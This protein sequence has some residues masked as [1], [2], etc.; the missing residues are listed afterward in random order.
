LGEGLGRGRGVTPVVQRITALISPLSG[1]YESAGRP[2]PRVASR[3]SAALPQPYRR[4]LVHDQ[5]MTSTL[6]AYFGSTVRLRVLERRL[7]DNSI[8][9]QVVLVTDSED[10][11]V[12][13]G[14]IHIRLDQ[15]SSRA[16]E[17]IVESVRPL[18]TILR[19]ERVAYRCD[20]RGFF[21]IQCDQTARRAFAL[22]GAPVLFGRHN[23]LLTPA[24]DMIAEVVE[25]LPPLRDE[26]A[27]DA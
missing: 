27:I 6:E 25:I 14:A 7:D 5:D 12:E 20:P 3:E 18:G 1:F 4:L 10:Q 11:P 26:G 8:T 21:E 15:F 24:G 13:F 16:R 22:S 2:L 9:R 19:E 23:L 17:R